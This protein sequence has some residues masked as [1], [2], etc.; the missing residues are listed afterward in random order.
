[1]LAASLQAAHA[2]T[3]HSLGQV[4]SLLKTPE[5]KEVFKEQMEGKPAPDKLGTHLSAGL[6][7]Q[8]VAALLLPVDGKTPAA[9]KSPKAPLNAIGVKPLPGEPNLY[10]AIVCTGGDIPTNAYDMKC[11]QFPGGSAKSPLQAHLGV[12]EMKPEGTPKLVAKP[13]VID[14]SVNWNDTGLPSAPEALDDAKAGDISPQQYDGFD[15]AAYWISKTQR[16]FGLRGVWFDG[17]SGG[18]G[19]YSALYLFAI[20]DGALKRVLAVPMAA[21]LDTAGDWNKD[22]TR[23]HDIT[24]GA[25]ILIVSKHSTNGHFD[26]QLKGRTGHWQRLYR[27]SATAAAY[28]RASAGH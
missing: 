9:A 16:A 17:Y 21:Y 3:A 23:N 12:I 26:L 2:E 25:N 24:Q 10:V 15:L 27:W 14:G 4:P 5:S 19:S 1:M 18:M 28:R 8:A 13:I 20:V 22:G 11:N 7:A 6:N